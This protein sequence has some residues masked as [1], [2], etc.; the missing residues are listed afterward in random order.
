MP[1]STWASPAARR[2]ASPAVESMWPWEASSSDTTRLGDGR[3]W[4][5]GKKDLR[6]GVL[7]N[8][9]HVKFGEFGV[10]LSVCPHSLAA[11]RRGEKR[12][13]GTFRAPVS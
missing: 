6:G 9:V 5:F 8:L 12:R 4:D 3:K 7:K 1:T 10:L 2:A 11:F 13:R